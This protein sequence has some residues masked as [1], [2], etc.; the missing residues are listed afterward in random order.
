MNT[1]YIIHDFLMRNNPLRGQNPDEIGLFE[2]AIN[3]MG[4]I[5]A[6]SRYEKL[7]PLVFLFF[8]E[9]IECSIYD[10]LWFAVAK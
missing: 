7:L 1:V 8:D 3:I 10:F 5:S 4:N 2:I 6:F 9:V